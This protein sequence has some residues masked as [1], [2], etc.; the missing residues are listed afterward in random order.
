M[1]S[2]VKDHAPSCH[3]AS[4]AWVHHAYQ[5]VRQQIKQS[6]KQAVSRISISFDVWTASHNIAVV[7]II[8]H[9]IDRNYNNQH[10]V[11][12]LPE[13]HGSHSGENITKLVIMTLQSFEI[14]DR[15]AFYISDNASAMDKAIRLLCEATGSNYEWSRLRCAAHIINIVV[16]YSLYSKNIGSDREISQSEL[17]AFID[18]IYKKT[19]G[20]TTMEE[21]ELIA[22]AWRRKGPL[23]KL[24]NIIVFVM[25]NPQRLKAFKMA[26]QQA[27]AIESGEELMKHLYKL[28]SDAGVRWNSTYNALKR[29]KLR[30][31]ILEL[32]K[33][34]ISNNIICFRFCS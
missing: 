18:A 34:F 21:A 22:A 29:G 7:G 26:Q 16:S 4:S 3:S 9:Y 31:L 10:V 5:A 27:A 6:L 13:L 1:N 24:H 33:H 30:K 11:I 25:R 8:A 32:K 23:G 28:I 2:R 17:Q 14:S 20:E 19:T 15:V 12:G